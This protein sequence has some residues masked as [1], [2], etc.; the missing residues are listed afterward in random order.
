MLLRNSQFLSDAGGSQGDGSGAWS[1]KGL[2]KVLLDL[3]QPGIGIG[4]AILVLVLVLVLR[5]WYPLMDLGQPGIG[6]GIAILVSVL[7]LQYLYP[8]MDFGQPGRPGGIGHRCH[9]RLRIFTSSVD[10]QEITVNRN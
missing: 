3:G 7:V 1:E 9:V 5:Y 6:I 8:L 4:I 2:R 10:A